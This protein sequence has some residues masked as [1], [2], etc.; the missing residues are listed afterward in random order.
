MKIVGL[1][2]ENSETVLCEE[3][4]CYRRTFSSMRKRARKKS[5]SFCAIGLYDIEHTP[6]TPAGNGV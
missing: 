1:F 6:I 3:E 5:E 2:I 4:S